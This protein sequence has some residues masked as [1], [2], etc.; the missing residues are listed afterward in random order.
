MAAHKLTTQWYKYGGG[1]LRVVRAAT[2]GRMAGARHEHFLRP[3][4]V[5]FYLRWR[6]AA[7]CRACHAHSI[8]HGDRGCHA[9]AN[10]HHAQRWQ[11]AQHHSRWCGRLGRRYALY[12]GRYKRDGCVHNCHGKPSSRRPPHVD[13]RFVSRQ[14]RGPGAARD[15]SRHH[16]ELPYRTKRRRLPTLNGVGDRDHDMRLFRYDRTR[17]RSH[18][19]GNPNRLISSSM[20]TTGT[21]LSI[22]ARICPGGRGSDRRTHRL[23][24][25]LSYAAAN[26]TE[27]F[28]LQ[29]TFGLNA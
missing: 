15:L 24:K 2:D 19:R 8:P 16:V 12:A 20:T 7:T 9:I 3:D 13:T 18:G 5:Q 27:S 10:H 1:W 6:R 28:F 4:W 26:S 29:T 25:A 22:Q 14:H 23:R 11:N 17:E 21:P